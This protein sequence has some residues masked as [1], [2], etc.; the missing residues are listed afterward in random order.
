MIQPS[1]LI[2][3]A[4]E[5]VARLGRS[6]DEKGL[7][8]EQSAQLAHLREHGYVIF[9]HL[10]G[11]DKLAALQA[12]YRK[13]V[14]VDLDFD[15]PTLAQSRID[16][17]RD[18]DL[19]KSNFLATPE[20]LAARGLAFQKSD[21]RTYDQAV[22]EFAPSTL[23][24]KLPNEIDW[25]D[26]WLDPKM[27]PIVEAYFGFVP[28]LVEAYIRR[29]FPARFPVMNHAWHRD[30]NHETHLLKGFVF[31]SD[32][33]LRTGPHHYIAGSV[34]DRRIDGKIYYSDEEIQKVYPPESGREIISVVPAGTIILEDTRGLHKAGIPD[35]GY[36]DLGYSTFVPPIALVG[37]PPLYKISQKTFED[38]S[39]AQKRY[40]P[41]ACIVQ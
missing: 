3:G 27:L 34:Q 5:K 11:T 19:I 32:C 17:V 35:E 25:F 31:L 33:T 24:T 38:L 41:A 12:D 37:R 1:V 18:E 39:P 14:E 8:A 13:R 6:A 10:V 23:T 2:R 16:P 28:E 30:R 15:F 22:A 9:D 4:L 40:V 36:R 7:S 29:N 20:Q 26:L 21:M